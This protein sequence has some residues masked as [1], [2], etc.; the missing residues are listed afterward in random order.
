MEQNKLWVVAENVDEGL[1]EASF[2]VLTEVARL[3]S[4]RGDQIMVLF[5]SAPDADVNK[6]GVELA[7]YGADAL[8]PL[9]VVPNS[10]RCVGGAIAD[11]AKECRPDAIF[12]A[13]TIWGHDVA[14]WVAAKLR[15]TLLSNCV[16]LGLGPDQELTVTRHVYSDTV[17]VKYASLGEQTMVITIQPG[18]FN[19]K[20]AFPGKTINLL[21][22]HA[23]QAQNPDPVQVLGF[24]KADPRTV[25]IVDAERLVV[26]GKGMGTAENYKLIHEVAEILGAAVGGTRVARDNGW[27]TLDR[28]IGQTGK[29]VAPELLI[30]CGVSGAIQHTMGLK[31]TKC[32]VA[33]NTDKHA[34][35]HKL[36]DL[37][38]V[39]DAPRV[40][41]EFIAK[42]KTG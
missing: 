26:G 24:I 34:P 6:I 19:V 13:E 20:K 32:L 29:T 40:L 8:L 23:A 9:E 10:S 30:S 2:E 38:I 25:D 18:L 16:E 4:R 21:E 14:A 42:I 12:I 31:E 3:A 27:V 5:C 15:T 37:S 22:R 1:R 28:Q 7:S 36:A 35:I 39:D 33:I 41:K 11:L 17:A